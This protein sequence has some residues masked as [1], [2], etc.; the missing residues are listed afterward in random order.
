MPLLSLS[1][2]SDGWSHTDG[3]RR[4]GLAGFQCC[5]HRRALIFAQGGVPAGL[6]AFSPCPLQPRLSALECILSAT[7]PRMRTRSLQKLATN[8][9]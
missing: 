6:L 3:Q 9:L 2:S 1:G 8:V 7:I 5:P 4:Y